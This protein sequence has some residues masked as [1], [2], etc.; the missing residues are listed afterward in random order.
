M[1]LLGIDVGGSGIKA[2]QVNSTTGKLVSERFRLPTPRPATP[3]AVSK[4]IKKILEHFE[5]DGPVGVSFPTVVKGG[6][7]LSSSNMHNDWKKIRID[8]HFKKHCGN[9]FHIV[10]DADAAAMA[11]MQYGAGKGKQG[12]VITIT[13]G[14][15]IGSGVYFNGQLLRNFELGTIYWKNGKMVE[16]YAADSARK[17]EDL[18]YERWGKRLNSYLKY[19]E[20][21]V[22]PDLFILGGG[23][24]RKLDRFEKQ[25]KIKTPY[26]AAKNLNNAGIIGAAV[27][28]YEHVS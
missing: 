22:H 18:S 11:E 26:V 7:A 6:K 25:I 9:N 19:I 23:V 5:W 3:D 10:N 13:I 15:G 8:K 14:T 16:L 28:A 21:T 20:K 1:T 17:R 4:T 2:A 12:L 27:F 24:S